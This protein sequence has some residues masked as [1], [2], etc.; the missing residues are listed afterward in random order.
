MDCSVCVEPFN[1]SVRKPVQCDMCDY[2][3]CSQCFEHYQMDHSGMHN[4]HCMNCK[5]LWDDQT[6]REKVASAVTQRLAA[7]TKKRLR[8]EEIAFMPET[9]LYVEYDK[10]VE[11]VKVAEYMEMVKQ[12]HNLEY[13]CIELEINQYTCPKTVRETLKRE[14]EVIKTNMFRFK[15]RILSWRR[16]YQLSIGFRD[17][18]PEALYQKHFRDSITNQEETVPRPIDTL[19]CPCPADSCRGFVM[20]NDHTCG[21]CSQTVCK[22][23]LALNSDEHVC[24][25]SDIQSAKLILKSSKPCPK[26]AARIHKIDG[27]DQMWCTQCQTSFSWTT[28]Q[29]IVGRV[30]HNPHYYEWLRTR[31]H[32]ENH[33]PNTCEGLPDA[34]YLSR[35]LSLVFKKHNLFR[36]HMMNLHRKCVHYREVDI[37]NRTHMQ[38][39]FRTNM[40]IRMKWLMNKTTDKAFETMLHKRYKQKLV[41]Q[42]IVQV[43]DLTVTLCTDVLHRLLHTNHAAD[44]VCEGFITEFTEIENYTNECFKK[45]EKVYKIKLSRIQFF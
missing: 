45:L 28:G 4:V 30:I 25:E 18:I 3:V 35:H 24:D 17:I 44:T 39:Q 6:V 22:H 21:V 42:R 9:Q 23:C 20:R 7:A 31:R 37:R 8:D 41:D 26:C 10:A 5:Q 43:Y 15:N 12:V 29:E 1:K 13:R 2:T 27:C 38:N 16:S 40:D 32:N 33:N 14:I 11:T 36:Q 34:I 19:L